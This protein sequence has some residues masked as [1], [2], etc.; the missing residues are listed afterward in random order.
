MLLM[1]RSTARTAEGARIPLNPVLRFWSRDIPEVE[2]DAEEAWLKA[3]VYAGHGAPA[4]WAVSAC[5][6]YKAS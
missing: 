5:D 6:R 4:F 3:D 2:R 1:P